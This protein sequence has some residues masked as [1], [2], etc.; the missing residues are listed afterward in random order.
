M[1]GLVST[2]SLPVATSWPEFAG[3]W[4]TAWS[5]VES[6][7]NSVVPVFASASLLV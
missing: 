3:D 7:S 5:S 2:P 6:M 1:T 4:I